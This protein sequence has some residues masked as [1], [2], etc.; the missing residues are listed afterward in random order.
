M[1]RRGDYSANNAP[2][3][4]DTPGHFTCST[5]ATGGSTGGAESQPDVTLDTADITLSKAKIVEGDTVTVT[6]TIR[7]TGAAAASDVNVRFADANGQIG[8]VQTI[9][10]IAAGGSAQASVAWT[11]AAV[12]GTNGEDVIVVTADHGNA[13]SET[14]EDNNASRRIVT[15]LGNKVANGSFEDGAGGGADPAAWTGS[16][17]VAHVSGGVAGTRAVTASG[18][19]SSWLSQAIG[20][21]GGASSTVSL[22]ASSS[23]ASVFVEQYDADGALISS[24]KLSLAAAGSTTAG[25]VTFH[26]LNGTLAAGASTTSI[27]LKLVGAAGTTTFDD[28][29]VSD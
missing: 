10:R 27:R 25:G 9:S 7:N 23:S 16:G 15:V 21:T 3:H 24:S 17:T 20:V 2:I 29:R 6:A 18:A 26:T 22:R 28:V 13:I 8:A 11:P 12:G 4:P 5:T 19:D 14:N 1:V